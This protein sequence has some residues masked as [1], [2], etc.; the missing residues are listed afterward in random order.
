MTTKNGTTRAATDREWEDM[1]KQVTEIVRVLGV[2]IFFPCI[3]FI[4]IC[5][6]LRSGLI[7]T[8]EKTLELF[9]RYGGVL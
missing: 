8:F 4:G 2:L 7:A 6:G 3:M 5:F 1:R 9:K